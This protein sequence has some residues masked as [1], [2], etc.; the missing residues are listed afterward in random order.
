[1]KTLDL[2]RKKCN[3]TQNIL[4]EKETTLKSLETLECGLTLHDY[5]NF[6]I[7]NQ[8]I[9]DEIRGNFEN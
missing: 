6:E 1:M 2:I 9:T 5:E 3:D 8:Q 4:E 7:K